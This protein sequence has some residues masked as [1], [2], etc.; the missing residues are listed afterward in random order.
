M[1]DRKVVLYI[2]ISLDGYIATKE[3]SLDWLLSTQGSGDNGFGEFYD[4]VETIIMGR[5]TY[6]WIMEQE[7]GCFPYVGK[8]CYVY[9]TQKSEDTEHVKFTSQ[10]PEKLIA[11]LNKE[12]KKIWIVGGSQIIDLVRKENLI[13]EYILN[14]APVILGSGIPLFCEREKENLVFDKVRTF[15]QF[16][17]V[18]YHVNKEEV[19]N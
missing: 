15:G 10:S 5:R 18:S 14:I 1:N 17:E 2:G 6:D 7:N 13:D 19:K 8:E 12:G 3:D 9:T 16:V 11:S 4:T